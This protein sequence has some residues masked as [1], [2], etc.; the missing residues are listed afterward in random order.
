MRTHLAGGFCFGRR[1]AGVAKMGQAKKLEARGKK[2]PVK[3]RAKPVVSVD[4]VQARADFVRY[5]IEQDFRSATGAYQRAYGEKTEAVAAACASRLLK[6]AKVQEALADELAAVLAE[7]RVPLEK[8]ILDTWIVRAFYD[9][10]EIISLKGALKIS[11]KELRARGLQV[12]IDSINKKVDQ[13]GREF[14]EYKLA[15]RDK[16]LD[17]L[18]KYIAMIREPD[19]NVNVKVTEPPKLELVLQ[20]AAAVASEPKP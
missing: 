7:R 19:K 15:D 9:P 18:Q 2:M 5:Y 14:I 3:K 6:D 17:M 4:L 20:V 11:E 13:R 16:A 1:G 8:R 12:C 10:T